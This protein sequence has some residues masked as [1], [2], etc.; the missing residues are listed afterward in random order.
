MIEE[1]YLDHVEQPAPTRVWSEQILLS[2]AGIFIAVNFLALTIVRP[3]SW[4][5]HGLMFAV[6]VGCAVVGHRLLNRYLPDRDHL[7]YPIVLFLS[8]WGLVIISRLAPRFA[9]RQTLW[10]IISVSALTAIAALPHPL[11]W[12]RQYRYLWLVCG[13]VLLVST[14]ILGS[15]PSG[16]EG[17]PQLWLGLAGVYFQP[18][19]ALK[20]ILVAFLASYL[21]EQYPSLRATELAR[22]SRLMSLSPRVVGPILLMWGLSVVILIWQRD[23]GTAVLFFVV[24]LMLLYIAS[25]YLPILISGMGLVLIAGY[26]AY[27]LFGVVQLRVDIWINPWPEAD[28]RAYQIVQSLQ[29]FAAGGVFGEGV[30]QGLPVFIPVVHSDFIFAALAEEWGLLGVF[31]VTVSIGTLV[32]RGCR[33][34]LLRQRQPFYA[35]MAAGL[36]TLIGVQSMM[37]M[38]GVIRLLPLTG[39]TLPFISYGGSSLLASYVM[40]GLLLRLSAVEDA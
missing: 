35:L 31:V 4:L 27:E 2:F 7:L 19:E 29:A 5:A 34:A 40:I 16:Q 10:L 3:D 30:G 32:V 15:N 33:T 25:G 12:L 23:L 36:S 20:V 17:A 37:I 26:V 39:V 28:T 24:F 13:L 18:S 6:W 9:H 8:G 14:I 11:R 22:G 38:G 1:A 21:A